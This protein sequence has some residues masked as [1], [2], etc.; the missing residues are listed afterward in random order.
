MEALQRRV[1][2]RIAKSLD[3]QIRVEDILAG[4]AS[5]HA[6]DPSGGVILTPSMARVPLIRS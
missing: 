2:R 5:G 4:D 3:E 6:S 1:G